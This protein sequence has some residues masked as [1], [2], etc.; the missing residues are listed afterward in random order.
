M[1]QAPPAVDF[2][3]SGDTFLIA[4]DEHLCT[5]CTIQNCRCFSDL[6]PAPFLFIE[7]RG[8]T[9]SPTDPGCAELCARLN[10]VRLIVPLSSGCDYF[11]DFSETFG[12]R[13]ICPSVDVFLFTMLVTCNEPEDIEPFVD[14]FA[15][16]Q[17]T[18]SGDAVRW[19]RRYFNNARFN[20]DHEDFLFQPIG[21]TFDG[22][23]TG[24][25]SLRYR[26]NRPFE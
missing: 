16:L 8:F 1:A 9:A 2:V 11:A 23:F 14:V 10:P 6:F 15:K 21:S 7:L 17:L 25:A 20:N 24:A 5:Q 26:F 12:R 18:S 4:T 3:C 19:Q 13:L 22:C